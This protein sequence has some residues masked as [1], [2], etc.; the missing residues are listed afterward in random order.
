MTLGYCVQ[1]TENIKLKMGNI[2]I[3]TAQQEGNL[4]LFISHVIIVQFGFFLS[5]PTVL[6]ELMDKV[7]VDIELIVVVDIKQ[8][9]VNGN[10]IA[11]EN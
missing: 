7:A 9:C 10:I 8:R 5:P 2:S 3:C 6:E 11:C 1:V 4:I